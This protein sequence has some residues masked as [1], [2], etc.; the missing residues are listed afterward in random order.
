MSEQIR[1][2]LI[3]LIVA[4]LFI[5]AFVVGGGFLA[6]IV[7]FSYLSG[8]KQNDRQQVVG[9]YK[10]MREDVKDEYKDMRKEVQNEQKETRDGIIDQMRAISEFNKPQYVPYPPCNTCPEKE[11]KTKVIVKN[12]RY[13]APL[14]NIVQQPVQDNSWKDYANSNDSRWANNDNKWAD[15][16]KKWEDNGKRWDAN[17]KNWDKNFSILENIQKQRDNQKQHF[18]P[19]ENDDEEW[20]NTEE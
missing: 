18:Q 15:N 12:N 8:T 16:D 20:H 1:N 14:P 10:E 17:D 3:G 2:L 9:E 13:Y 6:G 11:Q 7:G 4:I 19:R 5:A